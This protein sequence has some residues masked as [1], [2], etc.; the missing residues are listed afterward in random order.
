P[1][2]SGPVFMARV[3]DDSPCAYLNAS[4][5]RALIDANFSTLSLS[6]TQISAEALFA[7]LNS[8]WVKSLLEVIATPM[9]GGALK[10]EAAHLRIL[11]LP[12]LDCESITRLGG[13]GQNLAKLSR[14]HKDVPYIVQEIDETVAEQ[15]ATWLQIDTYR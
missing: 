3:N 4:S 8:I 14:I 9:G 13:L 6:T 5:S 10:V 7:L 15:V 1:R 12:S 11:P 2:H